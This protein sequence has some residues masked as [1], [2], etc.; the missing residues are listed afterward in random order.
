M[1]RQLSFD[2]PVREALGREDFFVSPANAT[3]VALIESWP[4]WPSHKLLL[5]GPEGAGK[6]HL[7]QVWASLSGAR[8]ISATTLTDSDIPAL[9]RG[10]VAVEDADRIAGC[11][12]AEEAL[13]HLH[14]LTLAEGGSLLITSRTPPARWGLGLPDLASR[15]QGTTQADLQP[16][17]DALLGAV[18]MKLMADRQLR[19]EPRLIPYLVPR[20]DRSF[21]AAR[22][23]V[24]RL[25]KA[26]LEQGAPITT[27]FA[28]KLLEG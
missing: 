4:D 24:E 26:A 23:I 25:D 19:P 17:D 16:P 28:A 15:M 14:N 22:E 5:T 12:P 2:L 10:P 21:Q 1:P 8:V 13:F 9:A 18:L 11:A 20:I 6:T 7:S 27:R 3:A